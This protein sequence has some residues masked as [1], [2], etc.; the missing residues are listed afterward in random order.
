MLKVAWLLHPRQGWKG[1]AVQTL[2]NKS[3]VDD[4]LVIPRQNLTPTKKA[5]EL[6]VALVADGLSE[7]SKGWRQ[8]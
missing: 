3:L 1:S 5:L 4:H 2:S 7:K 8:P 6:D